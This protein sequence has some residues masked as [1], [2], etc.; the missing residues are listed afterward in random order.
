MKLSSSLQAF[1]QSLSA[2]SSNTVTIFSASTNKKSPPTVAKK[3][4]I[5]TGPDKK[6]DEDVDDDDVDDVRRQLEKRTG[7]KKKKDGRVVNVAVENTLASKNRTIL[8]VDDNALNLKILSRFLNSGDNSLNVILVNSGQE[9]IDLLATRPVALVLMDIMMPGMDGYETT[10]VIR[11]KFSRAELP[12]LFV[13]A[14]SEES[15]GYEVGGNG[16]V[17]KPV[18]RKDLMTKVNYFLDPD[19]IAAAG[20]HDFWK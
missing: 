3:E 8:C 14:K 12:I 17:F 1:R 9:A 11:Q 2:S 18:R 15:R 6:D 19:D 5:V 10:T 4:V 13:T 7:R 20:P 16:F